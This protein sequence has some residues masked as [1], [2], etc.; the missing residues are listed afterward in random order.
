MRDFAIF[1]VSK[2]TDIKA[3]AEVKDIDHAHLL[4]CGETSVKTENGFVVENLLIPLMTRFLLIC[5]NCM[6]NLTTGVTVQKLGTTNRFFIFI[7]QTE[8]ENGKFTLTIS[9]NAVLS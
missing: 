3:K 5:E 7:R 6:P 4:I 2:L 8:S 1:L 9:I